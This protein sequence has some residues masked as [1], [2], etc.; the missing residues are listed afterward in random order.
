MILAGDYIPKKYRVDLG[1][2]AGERIL[3]NLEGPILSERMPPQ[4]LKAGSHLFSSSLGCEHTDFILSLANNHTMDYGVEGLEATKQYLTKLG[5]PYCGA[6][7]NICQARAPV[8]VEENGRRIAI[9]GCR[10]IQFGSAGRNKAGCANKGLWLFDTV[11]ALKRT[12]DFIIVSCHA[13][14]EH[15]PFPSPNLRGFYRH[16]VDAGV[17]VIHGHHSHIP[18][19][20]E[21]YHG[22]LILYGLG[23]FVVD[24]NVWAEKD[25]R[26]SM[27]AKIDFSKP[28]FDFE[29]KTISIE[30]VD[31]GMIR[32]VQPD[33][34]ELKHQ[35][36][37]MTVCNRALENDDSCEAYW[38]EISMRLF[39]RFY[40]VPL[41]FPGMQKY[42]LTLRNRLRCLLDALLDVSSALT[43]TKMVTR[44]SR[45]RACAFCNSHQCE[46][47]VDVIATASGV[48]LNEKPDMRTETTARDVSWLLG[49]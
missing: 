14:F 18:Q 17:N 23:N 1:L 29:I 41:R 21:M 5:I 45:Q 34:G 49:R 20:W 44:S 2:L 22:G 10:E 25:N 30:P 48:L 8:I 3:A 16:L 12:V 6:G 43:G 37:Y 13:A 46:S 39:D 15:S 35:L 4:I 40:G 24:P 42:R 26:W 38:Q 36:D 19:G 11:Q 9:L 7:D 28:Q 33:S 31:S 32:L 27:F 47:H